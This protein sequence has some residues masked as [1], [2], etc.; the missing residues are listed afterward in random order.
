MI[1]SG[2]VT[3]AFSLAR[4]RVIVVLQGIVWGLLEILSNITFYAREKQDGSQN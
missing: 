3:F 2:E 4:K 1:T